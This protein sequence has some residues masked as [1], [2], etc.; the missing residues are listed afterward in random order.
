LNTCSSIALILVVTLISTTFTFVLTIFISKTNWTYVIVTNF[1]WNIFCILIHFGQFVILCPFK[2]HMR[3]AYE[4]VLCGFWLYCV[5]SMVS[6]FMHI[7]TLWLLIPQ[8]VQYL[9]VFHVLLCVFGGATYITLCG[10]EIVLLISAIVIPYSHNIVTSLCCCSVDR[11]IPIV[12]IMKC[13]YKPT[14]NIVVKK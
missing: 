11:F 9:L 7:S 3:H 6:S 14:L 8:F 1:P 2:P 13:D 5:A 12:A 4:D 10:T